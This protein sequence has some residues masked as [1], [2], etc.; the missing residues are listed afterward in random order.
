[1]TGIAGD[2]T[3]A[4]RFC[5][6]QRQSV[7]GGSLGAASGGF[8]EGGVAAVERVFGLLSVEQLL[9]GEDLNSRVAGS[10]GGLVEAGFGGL[11]EHG[12]GGLLE[13]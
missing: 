1:M 12:F 13:A 7:V 4:S 8:F 6:R 9:D 11:F 5:W 2:S 10:V 3:P